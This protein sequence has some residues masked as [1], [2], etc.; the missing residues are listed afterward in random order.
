M[1]DVCRATECLEDSIAYRQSANTCLSALDSDLLASGDSTCIFIND[2]PGVN[3]DVI[4][5]AMSED[6]DTVSDYLRA[7]RNSEIK[8]GLQSFIN[9]HKELT[10][11]RTLIDN[12][13]VVKNMAYFSDKVTTNGR[14]VGIEIRPTSS[15]SI[16]AIVKKLGAQFD[17]IQSGLTIY[18]FESSQEDAIETF[19][20][21]S[22][23]TNSLQWFL[24]E[25]FV[26]R[27]K[28]DEGGTGQSFYVGYF[29]SDLMGQAI[30]TKLYGNCCGNDWVGAY[31]K[32]ALIRGV[33]FPAASLN[34]VSIP[35][36]KQIGYTDQTFGLSLKMSI[37]CDITDTIC[38]NATMFQQLCKKKVALKIMWDFYNNT[39]LNRKAEL[40]RDRALPNITRLEAEIAAELK[41]IKLDF[42]DIDRVCMPCSKEF[43]STV[44]MR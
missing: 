22:T 35:D 8:A 1:I 11:A 16:S 44:S 4:E 39:N 28:Y 18:F 26:A 3:Q 21:T 2:E 32:Y 41:G 30:D 14:F 23:K 36:L 38:E 15:Q 42:T 5:A 17:A 37:Q 31:Q 6:Y 24:P 20:L 7:V 33:V 29:E 10:R 34:G 27:Y 9:Q 19:S 13:D 43:I 40:S 12:L 25:N